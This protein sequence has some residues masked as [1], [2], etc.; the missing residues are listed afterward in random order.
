MADL[1]CRCGKDD[2][3]LVAIQKADESRVFWCHGCGRCCTVLG[4]D[5]DDPVEVYWRE[6]QAE[7]DDG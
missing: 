1:R 6:P 5:D 3:T 4:W 7:T 2:L